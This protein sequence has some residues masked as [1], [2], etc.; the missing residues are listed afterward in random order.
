MTGRASRWGGRSIGNLEVE[1]CGLELKNPLVIAAS[2]ATESV[3]SI[4]ACANAGASAVITKSIA[5]IER[6][7]RGRGGFRRAFLDQR[8]LWATSTFSRETLPL[9]VGAKLVSDSVRETEVPVI[10][11][12]AGSDLE[13]RHWVDSSLRL[14]EAGAAALQLD[15]FYAALDWGSPETVRGVASV[16][17]EIAASSRVPVVPKLNIDMPIREVVGAAGRA[18]AAGISFLDSI[19]LPPPITLPT[20]GSAFEFVS[21]PSRAS[22]FGRWQFPLTLRLTHQLAGET[23]LP[24][25]AGGGVWSGSD[26]LE[27]LLLGAR[28]VQIAT[29]VLLEG[30]PAISRVLRELTELVDTTGLDASQLS[31][32]ARSGFGCDADVR[33]TRAV[34][35][36]DEDLCTG[37]G[38]CGDLVFCEAISTASGAA[39]I[40]A[41]SCDGC[42][43]CV[44]VC[45]AR[46][47][48]LAPV[49]G[50]TDD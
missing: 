49:E 11:S 39:R 4:V 2:P 28:A 29:V 44:L 47:L 18:G 48:A 35:V 13:P 33:F 45:P 42:S 24:L 12:L 34:A 7:L 8:G 43:L 37:C 31:G 6:P 32:A 36:V 30:F 50:T 41:E 23:P 22:L 40:S 26:A 1:F 15:L 21:R 19:A 27:A 17:S 9:E 38:R 3:R 25:C 46:A 20:G 10:A 16:I 5:D 14:E